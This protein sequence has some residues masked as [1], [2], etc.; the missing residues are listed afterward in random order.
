MQA[1]KK[2]VSLFIVT[3][4]ALQVLN[5][6]LYAQDFN[7]LERDA[8]GHKPNIINSVTEYVAEVLMNK[9]N[10]FPEKRERP[11]QSDHNSIYKFQPF[12]IYASSS[13]TSHRDEIALIHNYA[14]F[15]VPAY[16]NHTTDIT[17]PP[18]KTTI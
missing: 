14:G 10:A 13:H 5:L 7:T 1:I 8:Y 12:K 9:R 2:Y 11:N 18:P 15:I 16:S 3:L 6:G 17:S 4:V